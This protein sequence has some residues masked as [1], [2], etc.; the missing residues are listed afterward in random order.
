M[1]AFAAFVRA[2]NLADELQRRD[3]AGFASRYNG[4]GYAANRYDQRMAEAYARL[5]GVA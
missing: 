5:K 3:W 4:P 2:N 1:A